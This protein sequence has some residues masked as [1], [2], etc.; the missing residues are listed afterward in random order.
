[1]S[2][3]QAHAYWNARADLLLQLAEARSRV[4]AILA[5]PAASDVPELDARYAAMAKAEG[6]LEELGR[7]VA[8]LDE[9]AD[10]EAPATDREP[11]SPAIE[12]EVRERMRAADAT[13]RKGLAEGG[14]TPWTYE[15]VAEARKLQRHWIAQGKRDHAAR[16]AR[17]FNVSTA[18]LR[19]VFARFPEATAEP[20][21]DGIGSRR[22]EPVAGVASSHTEQIEPSGLRLALIAETQQPRGSAGCWGCDS[23][24]CERVAKVMWGF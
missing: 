11:R 14:P 22:L 10:E 1:M 2:E 17:A 12:A 6:A 9:G 18:R 23:C 15:R 24:P 16:T 4:L 7:A 5:L 8:R 20:M 13:A 19:E 21:L 3:A